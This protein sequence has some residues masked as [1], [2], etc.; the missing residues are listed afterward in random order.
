MSETENRPLRARAAIPFL[1]LLIWG[2]AIFVSAAYLRFHRITEEGVTEE[3][4]VGYYLIALLWLDGDYNLWWDQFY[5]PVVYGLNALALH[6][7]GIND[8]SLKVF[9]GACDVLTIAL[10]I[11]IGKQLSGRYLCGLLA[12]QLYAVLPFVVRYA[13]TAMPHALS[14]LLVAA[15][16]AAFCVDRTRR[17]VFPLRL[18]CDGVCGMLVSLA[19]HTHGELALLGPGF[20][21]TQCCEELPSTLRWRARLGRLFCRGF[22]LTLGFAIPCVVGALLLGVER[23]EKVFKAEFGATTSTPAYVE[24]SPLISTPARIFTVSSDLLYHN[25]WVLPAFILM[26]IM[27]WIAAKSRYGRQAPLAGVAPFVLVATYVLAFPLTIGLFE[28]SYVRV[29]MPMLPLIFLA[30]ACGVWQST[31]VA[32]GSIGRAAFAVIVVVITLATP[33]GLFK[34]NFFKSE[35]DFRTSRF[36]TVYNAIGDRVTP[37]N[38]LLIVPAAAN[39]NAGYQL[40]F[41]FGKNAVFL[42]S[43]ERREPYTQ[44]LLVSTIE[45]EKFSY[46]FE[47][48][49]IDPVFAIA[50]WH[51]TPDSLRWFRGMDMKDYSVEAEQQLVRQGLAAADAHVLTTTP[52]GTIY[53]RNKRTVFP[54]SDFASGTL[55]HW[56]SEGLDEL[57]S[58]ATLPLKEY[59]KTRV[60]RSPMTLRGPVVLKGPDVKRRYAIDTRAESLTGKAAAEK[61]GRANLVGELV[62]DVFYIEEPVIGFRIAGSGDITNVHVALKLDDLEYRTSTAGRDFAC[63]EWNVSEH[64]GMRAQIIIRDTDPRQNRGIAVAGFYYVF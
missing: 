8:F 16:V 49:R 45:T 19:A 48:L 10:L 30:F 35:A 51:R 38:K 31:D 47:S 18:V 60:L 25:S 61:H 4:S 5:R 29:F 40:P 13:R 63:A 2:A 43:L 52:W 24:R 56:H 9:S 59:E 6:V 46:I 27:G 23:V 14:T 62:S 58:P 1:L 3:D 26:P 41:Y 17:L 11:C 57:F 39:S 55:D 64:V 37:E 32:R 22:A 50:N 44:D 15:A 54:N 12:A 42:S 28:A 33:N 34:P 36:R 7:I 20:F 53:S 21:A